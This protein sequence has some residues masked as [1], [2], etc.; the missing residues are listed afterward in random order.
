ME[1][2]LRTNGG[3]EYV[4]TEFN[5]FCESERIIHEVT[6]P[7]TPQHNGV[8]E[9]K[10]RTLLNMVRSMLKSK[11]LPKY[12]WGEAVNTAA[13]IL[14]RSPTKKVENMTP[15]EAWTG[16]KPC[17][18]HL[19]VFG[20]ICYRHVLDQV[21]T[22]LDDKGERMILLG[23][24]STGG[25]KL[26]NQVKNKIVINRDVVVDEHNEWKWNDVIEIEK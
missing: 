1:R 25:Y 3:G 19:R 9:R 6:P 12:L 14:N 24:H 2:V 7:Y 26:L 20:S 17:M 23:Y 11:N 5:E 8:A 22:K 4:S 16:V 21:R 10:N 18:S 15:E 13:Y